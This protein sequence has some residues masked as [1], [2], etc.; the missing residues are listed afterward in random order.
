MLAGAV[1]KLLDT[2]VA[3]ENGSKHVVTAQ[4][5][6]P[7]IHVRSWIIEVGEEQLGY[8]LTSGNLLHSY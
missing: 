1:P 7:G 6:C 4:R 2:D 3:K 8:H 5:I